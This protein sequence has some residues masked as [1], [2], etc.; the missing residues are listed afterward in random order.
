M[1]L[2]ASKERL[3]F[4]KLFDNICSVTLDKA[5]P[6]HKGIRGKKVMASHTLNLD[7]RRDVSGQVHDPWYVLD[8]LLV[9]LVPSAIWTL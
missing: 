5:V 8:W 2:S 9:G 4:T 3:Y 1:D 6:R 7:N